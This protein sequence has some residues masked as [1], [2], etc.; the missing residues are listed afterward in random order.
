NPWNQ[1]SLA[2]VWS[3]TK[4]VAA[5][6]CALAVEKG[7]L[8][9]EKKVSHYWPE[10]G[11]NGKEDITVG[12]LL[13][14]QAGIC[15]SATNDVQDY[16]NQETMAEELAAMKPIWE[17]GTA[18][19]YHSMTYG[20]L[21]SELIIRVTGKTLGTFYADE[22]GNPNEIDFFIG[23]PET[24]EKRVVEMVPFPKEENQSQ[25][26]TEINDAKRAT[27][28]G[29]N[30]IN[31]QNSRDWRSAEIPS[32][33]GQGC[34][35]GLAKLYSLV[36]TND[37]SLKILNE[38]TIV[39]MTK[40]RI[41]NRDL[42]LDV[43]TRWGAGFIMNMHKVIYGPVKRSFGH[44]GWG[45]SC[46]FGDPENNLGVSYVMNQMKNNFAADGRSLELINATYK[47]LNKD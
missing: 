25:G 33:N 14:H 18:S 10:F 31:L 6:T 23:L 45:G 13:S 27:A 42:V 40:E 46:A 7:L 44:S 26:S 20:W 2:T 12:M 9:Y 28:R 8:D 24:E 41:T 35:S 37:S 22:I 17:P 4:G 19:G 34:A 47:C 38:D 32:A 29:P 30:L 39:K 36:V 3:T 16:Y 11:C 15:G 43:V 21:T 5:I 1:D